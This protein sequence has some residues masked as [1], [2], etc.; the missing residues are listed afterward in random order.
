MWTISFLHVSLETAFRTH[1]CN[2]WPHP[3]LFPRFSSVVLGMSLFTFKYDSI[4]LI[5]NLVSCPSVLQFQLLLL[6]LWLVH[7]LACTHTTHTHTQRQALMAINPKVGRELVLVMISMSAAGGWGAAA[8]GGQAC[9]SQGTVYCPFHMVVQLQFAS[10]V[11]T[12]I[13]NCIMSSCLN[14][15]AVV[16][17]L[18]VFTINRHYDSIFYECAVLWSIASVVEMTTDWETVAFLCSYSA[19]TSA[20][21]QRPH[22]CRYI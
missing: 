2:L 22:S 17:I 16:C 21:V 4:V 15:E 14:W 13:S 7:S 8:Q 19:I 20:E 1:L 10:E 11:C 12:Y 6:L 18:T 3:A 5:K 9:I